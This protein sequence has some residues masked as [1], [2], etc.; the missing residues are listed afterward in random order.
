[1]ISLAELLLTEPNEELLKLMRA[2][3]QPAAIVILE[4]GLGLVPSLLDR[5]AEA[6]SEVREEHHGGELIILQPS[7]ILKARRK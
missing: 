1:M 4:D 3:R 7:I 5:P 2:E 6:A